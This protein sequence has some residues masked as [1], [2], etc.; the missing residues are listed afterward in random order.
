MNKTQQTVA[1]ANFLASGESV[2]LKANGQWV[3]DI[4]SAFIA[5]DEASINYLRQQIRS[6]EANA[7]IVDG[8]EIQV[9]N[10]KGNITPIKMREKHR[11]HKQPSISYLPPSHQQKAS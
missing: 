1:T 3:S 6:A 7:L 4:A 11:L 5:K 8:Y 2:F 9:E 10:E